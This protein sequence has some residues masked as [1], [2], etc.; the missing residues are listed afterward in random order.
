[1]PILPP[2]LEIRPADIFYVSIGDLM[3]KKYD[4]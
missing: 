2:N 3:H 1:M 4:K